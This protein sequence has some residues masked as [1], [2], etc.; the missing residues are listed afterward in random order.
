MPGSH[1]SLFSGIGAECIAIEAAGYKTI[2]TAEIDPF[3]RKVLAKRFPHA[4]HL[5]DVQSVSPGPVLGY[6]RQPLL[7][8]GGFP[9]QDISAP[10]AGLGLSGARSGLWSEFKRVIGEFQPDKVLIENSPMLRSRGLEIILR[11]LAGLGYDA[12]WDCI[13]AA[14]VGAP[15]LRDRIFIVAEPCKSGL[16]YAV[17]NMPAKLSRAGELYKGSVL[18]RE[19]LAPQKTAKQRAPYLLPTPRAAA[20]EW[21]TTRNA[22]SHGKTHGATLAGTLNDMERAAGRTPASSS[23]SAGNIN[24]CWVEWFMGLPKGWTRPDSQIMSPHAGWAHE[25]ISVPRTIA[26]AYERRSRLRALGNSLVPQVAIFALKELSRE[27]DA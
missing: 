24:P 2:A 17:R 13:P 6:T 12:R 8:S 26:D 20:N 15:H 11:D 1:I 3:C 19:P 23:E 9:C 16:S 14:F 25:P 27:P 21:R 4:V 10:G 7:I 18:S 22:P 5:P